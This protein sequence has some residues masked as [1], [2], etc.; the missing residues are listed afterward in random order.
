MRTRLSG[1]VAGAEGETLP[2]YADLLSTLEGA[3]NGIRALQSS[4]L[5]LIERD[6]SSFQSAV[7]QDLRGCEAS[8]VVENVRKPLR[9]N[10]A[11]V[12]LRIF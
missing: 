2:P 4:P 11:H 9:I 7:F 5:D 6:L 10:V 8:D 3:E 1:G 12:V